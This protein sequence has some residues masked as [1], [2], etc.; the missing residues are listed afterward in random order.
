MK[1]NYGLSAVLSVAEIPQHYRKAA[2]VLLN[3]LFM[4]TVHIKILAGSTHDIF[5]VNKKA[6]CTSFATKMCLVN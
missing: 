1:N 4:G 5:S 3:A 2:H 6:S